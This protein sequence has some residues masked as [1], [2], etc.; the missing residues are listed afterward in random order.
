MI[1]IINSILIY[2]SD[3]ASISLVEAQQNP[4]HTLTN[5]N[6][7][8]LKLLIDNQGI[9]L[10]KEEC[11][12]NV[13]E[14]HGLEGSVN[15]LTQYI[16]NLRK[17]FSAYFD[18]QEVIVTVPRKGYM[19]SSSVTVT[20]EITPGLKKPNDKDLI[21][22]VKTSKIDKWDVLFVIVFFSVIGASLYFHQNRTTLP[23]IEQVL[24]YN[25]NSCPV[26]TLEVSDDKE[27]I[28]YRKKIAKLLIEENKLSCLP[29]SSFYLSVNKGAEAG[30][31]GVVM[32]ARCIDNATASNSCITYH[33]SRW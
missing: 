18:E 1:Y 24:L 15:T 21:T 28:E 8:L 12:D 14:A 11:L 32:L 19:L 3:N 29:S 2:D 33:Y 30:I 20:N 5:I 25:Y 31:S 23:Q 17:I 22:E 10:S 13:W 9:V 26:Y 6:N 27:T 7:R 16:S 4:E